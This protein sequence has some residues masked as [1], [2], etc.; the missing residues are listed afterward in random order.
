MLFGAVNDVLKHSYGDQS[1]RYTL[2]IGPAAMTLSIVS[3]AV[4]SR[5]IDRDVKAVAGLE[6][7]AE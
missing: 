6:S 1:L 4:A 5:F 3:F 7:A 2:L